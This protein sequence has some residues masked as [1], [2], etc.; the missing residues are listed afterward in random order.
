VCAHR[1]TYSLG[2]GD[3][4]DSWRAEPFQIMGNGPYWVPPPSKKAAAESEGTECVPPSV[5]VCA[6]V[7]VSVCMCSCV[8]V[9]VSRCV[10]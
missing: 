4:M 2:N 9:C 8:C 7:G 6:C 5:C 10:C 3:S 1:K